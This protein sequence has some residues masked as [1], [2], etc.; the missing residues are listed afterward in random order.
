VT[1]AQSRLVG[2][3]T[4]S[5]PP[6]Q[7]VLHVYYVFLV[8]QGGATKQGPNLNGLFGRV[9]G[10]VPGYAY[11]AANKGSGKTTGGECMVHYGQSPPILVVNRV[12]E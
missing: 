12:S 9:A 10:S 3:I 8:A 4:E 6:Q 11:S 2:P 7:L 5:L 1:R